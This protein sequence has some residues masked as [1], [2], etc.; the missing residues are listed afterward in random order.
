[1]KR[2]HSRDKIC[3]CKKSKQ[4]DKEWETNCT[5]VSSYGYNIRLDPDPGTGQAQTL[6]SACDCPGRKETEDTLLTEANESCKKNV[7]R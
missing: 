2:V 6:F 3:K 7:G 5:W 1:M 4:E